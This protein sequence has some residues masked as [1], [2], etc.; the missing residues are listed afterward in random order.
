MVLP[1]GGRA[2]RLVL[3]MGARIRQ[4]RAGRKVVRRR[5]PGWRCWRRP[6]AERIG[7]TAGCDQAAAMRPL[8][9]M[10]SCPVAPGLL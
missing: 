5:L 3:A 1:P 4:H 10:A 9:G 7:C 8:A 2:G 6:A